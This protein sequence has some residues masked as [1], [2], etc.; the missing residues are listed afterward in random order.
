MTN[1]LDE[2][3]ARKELLDALPAVSERERIR[4]EAGVSLREGAEAIGC[5]RNWLRRFETG[6]G[7]R[8]SD[9]RLVACVRFYDAC[10]GPA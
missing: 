9:E 3:A 7:T 4:Q 2:I 6:H 5:P 10:R 1:L 8:L